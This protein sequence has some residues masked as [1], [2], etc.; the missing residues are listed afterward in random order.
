MKFK[1]KHTHVPSGEGE[2][3]RQQHLRSGPSQG[4]RS[5]HSTALHVATAEHFEFSVAAYR[6][7]MNAVQPMGMFF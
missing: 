5:Y 6:N 4:N 3:R 1:T 7:L 2:H